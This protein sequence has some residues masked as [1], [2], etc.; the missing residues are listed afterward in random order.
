MEDTPNPAVW[1]MLFSSILGFQHHPGNKL[2]L[3]VE[4]CAKLADVAYGEYLNRVTLW[5]G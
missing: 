2:P 1:A 5:R 3:S 4:D